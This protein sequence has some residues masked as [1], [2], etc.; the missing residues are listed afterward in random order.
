MTFDAKTILIIAAA[1][2]VAWYL[3]ARFKT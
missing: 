2:G 3:G 1:F